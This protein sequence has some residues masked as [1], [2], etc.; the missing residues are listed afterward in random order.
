VKQKP[1]AGYNIFYLGTMPVATGLFIRNCRVRRADLDTVH[2]KHGVQWNWILNHSEKSLIVSGNS[3][4]FYEL[5]EM[6][7]AA[8]NPALLSLD[9]SY[10]RTRYGEGTISTLPRMTCQ[11]LPHV[12]I[13]PASV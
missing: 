13:N 7:P 9:F 10:C 11:T 1:A 2:A 8:K 4:G 5:T 6:F 12:F 3:E